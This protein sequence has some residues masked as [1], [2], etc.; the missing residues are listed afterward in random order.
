MIPMEIHRYPWLSM[1]IATKRSAGRSLLC[2]ESVEATP[3][4]RLLRVSKVHWVVQYSVRSKVFCCL[5]IN[6]VAGLDRQ[7]QITSGMK[8]LIGQISD[9]PSTFTSLSLSLHLMDPWWTMN[10]HL[11]H[12]CTLDELFVGYEW[13]CNTPSAQKT[14]VAWT[15]IAS[16]GWIANGR[17]RAA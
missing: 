12:S 11:I 2:S 5:D 17:S 1:D 13:L 10:L 16:R 9:T 8:S 7:R 15:S 4:V 14:F 3:S 6:S